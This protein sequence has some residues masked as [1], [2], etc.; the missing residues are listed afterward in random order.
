MTNIW[1]KG[2]SVLGVNLNSGLSYLTTVIKSETYYF[3]TKKLWETFPL[4]KTFSNK[5]SKNSCKY[6]PLF[7]DFNPEKTKYIV[8]FTLLKNS[9]IR[10][11]RAKQ[12]HFSSQTKRDPFRSIVELKIERAAL[13]IG[14]QFRWS[15]SVVHTGEKIMI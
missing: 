15:N 4:V 13:K 3:Y 9:K 6:L 8:S 14:E 1:E 11:D 12:D 5:K 2:I 10:H 7:P